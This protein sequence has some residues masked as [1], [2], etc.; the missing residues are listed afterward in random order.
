MKYG[1]TAAL[2][3]LAAATTTAFAHALPSYDEVP[4]GPYF[5]VMMNDRP[6]HFPETPGLRI[7]YHLDQHYKKGGP[8]EYIS[9]LLLVKSQ[10]DV[11]CFMWSDVDEQRYAEYMLDAEPST[12]SDT[13]S[14]SDLT[15]GA[16]KHFVSPVTKPREW[17]SANGI[18]YNVF[19]CYD[20]TSSIPTSSAGA[21][22]ALELADANTASG[23][24]LAIAVV[25]IGAGGY[26]SV[27]VDAQDEK[28]LLKVALLETTDGESSSGGSV[29][30]GWTPMRCW[31]SADD[32]EALHDGAVTVG[33]PVL[34]P[35]DSEREFDVYGVTCRRSPDW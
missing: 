12:R 7:Q 11:K 22:L 35:L 26:G 14:P 18:P 17:L 31:V 13:T 27:F 2:L 28:P 9:E 32:G 19:A 30:R 33:E 8:D 21:V 6:L 23:K 5:T 25:G 3:Y 24:R 1:F 16:G 10:L 15:T 29:P 20:A 4:N 34:K